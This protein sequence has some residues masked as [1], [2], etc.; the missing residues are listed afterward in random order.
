[1]KEFTKEEAL[2][3]A[4]E[5][6]M[7]YER[8]SFN[9][10]ASIY[11]LHDKLE[12]QTKHQKSFQL[13]NLSIFLKMVVN[14]NLSKMEELSKKWCN[15]DFPTDAQEEFIK[16]QESLEKGLKEATIKLGGLKRVWSKF[17]DSGKMGAYEADL[18]DWHEARMKD[19]KDNIHA[20][21]LS[22]K[23]K[24]NNIQDKLEII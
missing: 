11:Y 22:I 23:D 7:N 4:S 18:G 5:I 2:M 14:T 6:I 21:Y 24:I 17:V 1:M 12:P 16:C 15:R 10:R 3:S 19:Y 20:L 8:F 13:T 9:L